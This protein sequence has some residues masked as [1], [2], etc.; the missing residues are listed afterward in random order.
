MTT[1]AAS[2]VNSVNK[3]YMSQITNIKTKS[4]PVDYDPKIMELIGR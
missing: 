3:L 2:L 4:A 1:E